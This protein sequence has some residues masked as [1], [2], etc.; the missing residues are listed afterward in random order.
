VCLDVVRLVALAMALGRGAGKFVGTGED[1][2]L[3]RAG[4]YQAVVDRLGH[5]ARAWVFALDNVLARGLLEGPYDG[6]GRGAL[7]AVGQGVHA[8]AVDGDDD[9]VVLLLRLLGHGQAEDLVDVLPRQAELDVAAGAN[10]ADAAVL[11]VQ[12]LEGELLALRHGEADAGA[13]L[14]RLGRAGGQRPARRGCAGVC[15][16]ALFQLALLRGGLGGW[17]RGLVQD[18]RRNVAEERCLCGVF[19][20]DHVSISSVYH[21]FSAAQHTNRGVH[22]LAQL[23]VAGKGRVN[24]RGM[25]P[26]GRND[27]RIY[28]GGGHGR[29]LRQAHLSVHRREGHGGF[30]VRLGAIWCCWGE[31]AA[32][33]VATSINLAPGA[34]LTSFVAFALY[35]TKQTQSLSAT[36]Q[37]AIRGSDTDC[38]SMAV[39]LRHA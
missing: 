10:R 25:R 39:S 34:R 14:E 28:D 36:E 31:D 5:G 17:L 24:L 21:V 8:V 12:Q 13:R 19:V 1:D 37:T 4:L 18:V 11:L 27:G 9:E 20:C 33:G 15:A 23:V 35:T 29:R 30:V 7:E 16:I 6:L 22:A 26:G 3:A 32:R 2:L 38:G